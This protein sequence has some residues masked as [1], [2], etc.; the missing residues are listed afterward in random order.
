MGSG[1]AYSHKD[2]DFTRQKAKDHAF[3]EII[4]K[5]ISRG[6]EVTLDETTPLYNDLGTEVVEVGFQREVVF[7]LG[8]MNFRLI[9][10]VQN[11]RINK[12][13]RLYSTEDLESPFVKI[14]LLRK[15]ELSTDWVAI[16]LD[17][18]M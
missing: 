8:K 12:S 10:E 14:K 17:A 9:R 11:V 6:G 2:T 7:T 1:K 18:I 13:G 3:E 4:E 5:I 16:D 15:D